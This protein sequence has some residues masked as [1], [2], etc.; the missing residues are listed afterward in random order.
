M[1]LNNP[2]FNI[3]LIKRANYLHRNK[4]K[5]LENQQLNI[6]TWRI[7]NLEECFVVQL[8]IS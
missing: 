4:I 5:P 3:L 7:L 8:G 1:L 2:Q 6:L